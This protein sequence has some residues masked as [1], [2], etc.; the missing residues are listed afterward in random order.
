V[1]I[2]L[3]TEKSDLIRSIMEGVTFSLRD[4]L[5]LLIQM[6]ARPEVIHLSG[7]GSLSPL[8]RQI[9][10]D[11]LNR[12]VITLDSSEDASAVGAGV[13]AGVALGIWSS[14]GEGVE[15]L[16]VKTVTHPKEKNVRIYQE[17][18]DVYRAL[19]PAVK[20]SFDKLALL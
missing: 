2:R 20:P 3:T 14:A 15:S 18:F 11:I 6:G 10:A 1:G 12:E 8:W 4:V 5:E 17:M 13:I 7:G 16:H 9:H 19:Y